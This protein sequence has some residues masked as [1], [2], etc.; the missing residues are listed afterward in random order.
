[1]E[2]GVPDL[3]IALPNGKSL[4]CELKTEAKDSKQSPD[5]I[6]LQLKLESLGH[7]YVVCRNFQEFKKILNKHIKEA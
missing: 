5:Q 4:H 3:Y 6:A 2:V 7:T 1:M